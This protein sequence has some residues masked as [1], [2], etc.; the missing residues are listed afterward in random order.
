MYLFILKTGMCVAH[1][2]I[3]AVTVCEPL[4]VLSC[5]VWL[6]SAG[7][8]IFYDLLVGADATHAVLRLVA[9]LFSHAQELGRPVPLPA[10]PCQPAGSLP[11]PYT[12]PTGNYALL[13]AKQPVPR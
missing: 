9:G 12:L 5:S 2:N 3:G 6:R 10:V 11:Y 7:F 1:V 13:S 4:H 8:V